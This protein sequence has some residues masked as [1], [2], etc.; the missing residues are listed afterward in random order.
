MSNVIIWMHQST[1][2]YTFR[3]NEPGRLCAN[4]LDKLKEANGFKSSDFNKKVIEKLREVQENGLSEDN[5]VDISKNEDKAEDDAI[6]YDLGILR[7]Y[8]DEE[9]KDKNDKSAQIGGNPA[10]SAIRG[11]Y[12]RGGRE[13]DET[14]LPVSFYAGLVPRTVRTELNKQQREDETLPVFRRR[15]IESAFKIA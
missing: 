15:N 7:K 6:V 9:I 4:I 8:L 13:N 10:I 5:R 11:H 12:L 2:D 1:V 3:I 14:D